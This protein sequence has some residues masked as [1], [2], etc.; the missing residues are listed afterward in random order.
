MVVQWLGWLVAELSRRRT[1]FHPT[2]V[3]VGFMAV[4]LALQLFFYLLYS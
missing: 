1:G 4:K 3:R 2:T